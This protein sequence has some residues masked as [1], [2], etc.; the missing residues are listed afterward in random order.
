[1]LCKCQLPCHLVRPECQQLP[2]HIQVASLGCHHQGCMTSASWAADVT[3]DKMY[4]LCFC[5]RFLFQLQLAIQHFPKESF[6]PLDLHNMFE[7][8]SAPISELSYHLLSTAGA[9]ESQHSTTV[10]SAVLST[11][12]SGWC[13]HCRD[14]SFKCFAAIIFASFL[15]QKVPTLSAPASNSC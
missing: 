6:D 8:I 5:A 7:I 12:F 13:H 2:C 10:L 3:F 15:S 1:M 9:H 4:T 14:V 11:C